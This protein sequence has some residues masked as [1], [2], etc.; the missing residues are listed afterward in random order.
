MTIF[1]P[2]YAIKSDIDYTPYY[3]ICK[4]RN[5]IFKNFSE[6]SKA[7]LHLGAAYATSMGQGPA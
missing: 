2:K 5:G 3:L 7:N 1:R 4:G 6:K